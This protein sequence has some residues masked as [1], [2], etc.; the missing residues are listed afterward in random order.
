MSMWKKR[1]KGM[2]RGCKGQEYRVRRQ[3]REE[4]VCNPFN[5]ESG[6]PGCC[7][8]TVRQTLDKMPTYTTKELKTLCFY[9]GLSF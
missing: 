3:E 8:V 2:E 5:S 1:E 6:I 7:Q 9:L 4:W